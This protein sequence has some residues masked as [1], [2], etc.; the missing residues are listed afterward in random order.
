MYSIVETTVPVTFYALTCAL[1]LLA[2]DYAM[3]NLSRSVLLALCFSTS[4]WNAH[5]A[6][7]D[8]L[9]TLNDKLSRARAGRSALRHGKT[10]DVAA[11]IARG[12][13][14]TDSLECFVGR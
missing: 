1:E 4:I 14:S 2:G 8:K 11:S 5:G 9:L 6:E 13:Q 12:K 10:R 3:S 7:N